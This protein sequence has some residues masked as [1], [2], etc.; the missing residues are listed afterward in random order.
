M[1]CDV[2]VCR[3]NTEWF[4]DIMWR[5]APIQRCFWLTVWST[6]WLSDWII[7]WLIDRSIAI[8]GPKY[9]ELNF[10]CGS[11]RSLQCRFP[12]DDVLLRS[13]DIRDQV[14]KLR[15]IALKTRRFGPPYF[16]GG[17]H[18]KFLIEFYKSGS[19]SNVWQSLVTI[20]QLK[21]PRRLGG[22]KKI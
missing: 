8:C 10:L 20:G 7:D 17:G 3:V 13:G 21:G 15:E 9:T 16:G 14:A 19:P 12:I 1:W 11:V 22:E 6:D 2:S 18:P 5:G 4:V